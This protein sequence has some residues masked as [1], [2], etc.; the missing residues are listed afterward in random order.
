MADL[1]AHM[2][3]NHIAA[4]RWVDRV[5]LGYFVTGAL[6]PDLASRVPRVVLNQLVELGWLDS[7]E[8]TFRL[9][10]G[11]DFP[12]T[13][14]GVFLVAV[15]VAL[16]LP[17]RLAQPPGRVATWWMLCLG[18]WLHLG[19]DLMQSHLAPGYR[20]FYPFT[21][22]AFELGW[23]S[24]EQSLVAVPFL[25]LIAWWLSRGRSAGRK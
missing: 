8:G 4:V 3:V 6:M 9:M 18:G 16:V 10:L 7:T 15:V 24:T 23:I 20:Y 21:V 22:R 17:E 13:P 19:V 1:A 12:H 11:L 5:R 25:G 14:L 2:L